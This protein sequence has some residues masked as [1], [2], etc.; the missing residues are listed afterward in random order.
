MHGVRHAPPLASLGLAVD[1]AQLLS[2]PLELRAHLPLRAEQRLGVLRSAHAVQGW[3]G[4]TEA[5][6]RRRSVCT[7]FTRKFL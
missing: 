3:Y 2:Q 7:H 1:G 4:R 5:A 6:A